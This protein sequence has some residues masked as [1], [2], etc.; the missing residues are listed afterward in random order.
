MARKAGIKNVERRGDVVTISFQVSPA[1][2]DEWTR[3]AYAAGLAQSV[4]FERMFKSFRFSVVMPPAEYAAML[5]EQD[6]AAEQ[7]AEQADAK[8]A[9]LGEP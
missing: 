5:Q 8:A 7:A 6:E 2:R 3:A 1:L 9:W 4:Y